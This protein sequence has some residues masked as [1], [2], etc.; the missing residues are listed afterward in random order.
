MRKLKRNDYLQFEIGRLF[1]STKIVKPYAGIRVESDFSTKSCF[2]I[3]LYFGIYYYVTI[4][5]HFDR[6][7]NSKRNEKA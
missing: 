6:R 3:D 2:E 1:V 4:Y 7:P 5:I